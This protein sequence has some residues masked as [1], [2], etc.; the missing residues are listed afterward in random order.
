MHIHEQTELN[1][2]ECVDVRAAHTSAL[3][4][5]NQS[6]VH[7]VL[8]GNEDRA[9]QLP[10]QLSRTAERPFVPRPLSSQVAPRG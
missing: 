8:L 10:V 3:A 4:V 1:A 7:L 9:E 2:C 5:S 6:N